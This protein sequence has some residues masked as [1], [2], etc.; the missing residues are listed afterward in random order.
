[1]NQPSWISNKRKALSTAQQQVLAD[2]KKYKL[3]SDHFDGHEL[4]T[5]KSLI[6]AGYIQET[7][8]GYRIL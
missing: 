1:M 4:R 7:D 6:D 8:R 5:I 2:I 3:N